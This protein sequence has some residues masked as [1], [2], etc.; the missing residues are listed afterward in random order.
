MLLSNGT[1]SANGTPG[2]AAKFW[3][4]AGS[5]A[6]STMASR[7]ISSPVAGVHVK[8]PAVTAPPPGTSGGCTAGDG[9][10]VQPEGHSRALPA[11]ARKT[12]TVIG[13]DPTAPRFLTC[14]YTW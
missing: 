1:R 6:H 13:P 7:E 14:T 9:I 3:V 2:A 8:G 11:A 5:C 12:R 10:S 4:T